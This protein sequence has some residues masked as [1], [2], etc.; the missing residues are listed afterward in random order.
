[1]I[2]LSLFHPRAKN[3]YQK[4]PVHDVPTGGL[5]RQKLTVCNLHSGGHWKGKM[6]L[7]AWKKVENR[8]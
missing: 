4:F 2:M 5:E 7:A 8:L 6:S 3:S 1:M